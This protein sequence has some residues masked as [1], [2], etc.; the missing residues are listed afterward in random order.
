MFFQILI[1]QE[2]TEKQII[3][4]ICDRKGTKKNKKKTFS[5]LCL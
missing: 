5:L 2:I 3:R 1:N 4:K